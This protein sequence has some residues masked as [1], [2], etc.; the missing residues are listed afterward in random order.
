MR[1]GVRADCLVT[2]C[3]LYKRVG[4]MDKVAVV[5]AVRAC[6]VA[7]RRREVERTRWRRRQRMRRYRAF[8]KRQ[9]R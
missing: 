5:A 4:V 9:A 3:S 2:T 6:F 7:R 8:A 1:T